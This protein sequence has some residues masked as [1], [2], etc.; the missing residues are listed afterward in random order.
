MLSYITDLT[1]KRAICAGYIGTLVPIPTAH[2]STWVLP[3][4]PQPLPITSWAKMTSWTETFQ[5]RSNPEMPVW[6]PWPKGQLRH[7]CCWPRLRGYHPRWQAGRREGQTN[8]TAATLQ[9]VATPFR[10][11]VRRLSRSS[12]EAERPGWDACIGSLCLL[13]LWLQKTFEGLELHRCQW[14]ILTLFLTENKS[15]LSNLISILQRAHEVRKIGI[16]AQERV[17]LSVCNEAQRV[18]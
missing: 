16:P 8:S 12:E 11:T 3:V 4:L 17:F 10:Q 13:S 18:I 7:L 15:V 14:Q 1:V 9:L 6:L 5:A 2:S